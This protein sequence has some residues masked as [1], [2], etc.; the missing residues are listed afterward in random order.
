MI[1]L[2]WENAFFSEIREAKLYPPVNIYSLVHNRPR[3]RLTAK[4]PQVG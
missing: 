4:D 2:K 1:Y 3:L